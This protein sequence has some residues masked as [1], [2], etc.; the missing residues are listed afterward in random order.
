MT[1]EVKETVPGSWSEKEELSKAIRCYNLRLVDV[2]ESDVK[3]SE[4]GV[5]GYAALFA[6]TPASPSQVGMEATLVGTR[7]AS[8]VAREPPKADVPLPGGATTVPF[9]TGIGYANAYQRQIPYLSSLFSGS[10]KNCSLLK[11]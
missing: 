4:L 5:Q 3:N 10:S 7:A 9:F 8:R 1:V 11:A 6:T 2:C